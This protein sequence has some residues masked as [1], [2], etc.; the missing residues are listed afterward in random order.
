MLR[1]HW[2]LILLAIEV[3][4]CGYFRAAADDNFVSD[5]E[6]A[7]SHA[8]AE[9]A[10]AKIDCRSQGKV[11]RKLEAHE[12]PV[13]RWSN[14]EIGRVFGDVFVYTSNGRPA[15]LV[16][17]YAWHRPNISTRFA[18]FLSLS[19][20]PLKATAGE[21]V[22]WNTGA[23][24]LAWRAFEPSPIPATT[25]P[26]RLSQMRG[27]AARFNIVLDARGDGIRGEPQ[28]LRKLPRPLFRYDNVK[29]GLMD[30]ALFAFVAS[31]DPDAILLVEAREN[32]RAEKSWHYALA[33]MNYDA[34][35]IR[36]DGTVVEQFE[37]AREFKLVDLTRPYSVAKWTQER[38]SREA[39]ESIS[40]E[41]R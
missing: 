11:S 15:A 21:N 33:R 32:S 22:L 26:A 29:T 39:A 4:T 20:E 38:T 36:L 25:A 37:H 18:E 7:E 5:D 9:D 35:T 6:A 31:T 10:F 17:L 27:L 40:E 19:K 1:F 41:A 2:L 14:P 23:G 30:G 28:T 12:Q 16:C 3:A 34:L 24:D 13:L 8:W